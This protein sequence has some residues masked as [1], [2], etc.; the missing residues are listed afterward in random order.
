[1]QTGPMMLQSRRKRKKR[2]TGKN[3]DDA[4]FE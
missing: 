2:I 1:L 4:F 3:P